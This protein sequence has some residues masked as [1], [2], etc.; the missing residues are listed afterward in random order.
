M[1]THVVYPGDRVS[2]LFAASDA[3]AFQALAQDP[4]LSHPEVFSGRQLEASFRMGR[5][6]YGYL[7]WVLSFGQPDAVSTVLVLLTIASGGAASAALA[8]LARSVVVP[9]WIAPLFLILPGASGAVWGTGPELLALALATFGIVVLLQSKQRWWI[10]AICLVLAVLARE[11]MLIVPVVMFFVVFRKT[12]RGDRTALCV[13]CGIPFVALGTWYLIVWARVGTLPFGRKPATL[14][15]P[16]IGIIRSAGQWDAMSLL[17][18]LIL[19]LIVVAA[20]LRRRPPVSSLTLGY[21]VL[22]VVLTA[23]TWGRSEDFGRVLLPLYAYGLLTLAPSRTVADEP[24][25][26]VPCT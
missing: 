22:A 14:G 13:T 21:G 8:L 18:A 11:T 20:I 12:P 4:T 5:P 23:A 6:L 16:G 10:A 15:L 2:V 19:A 17:G 7:G 3:Q 1:T 26:Q 9:I 24:R 25:E